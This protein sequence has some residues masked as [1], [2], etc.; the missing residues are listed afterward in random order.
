MAQLAAC[1]HPT[2]CSLWLCSF[3]PEEECQ[4]QKFRCQVTFWPKI[5]LSG[6]K[7]VLCHYVVSCLE[8]GSNYCW[9]EVCW[10]C[11]T[12]S[13][14][15][16]HWW[17]VSLPQAV[18]PSASLSLVLGRYPSINPKYLCLKEFVAACPAYSEQEGPGHEFSKLKMTGGCS[19]LGKVFLYTC[20]AYLLP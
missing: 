2:A 10:L 13:S 18:W 19:V 12:S 20:P 3:P 17:S 1:K 15:A 4:L 9:T 14:S 11:K 6:E 5:R 8:F 7:K 16:I